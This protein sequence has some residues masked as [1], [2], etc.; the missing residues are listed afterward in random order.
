ML[1]AQVGLR[2][3]NTWRS[4]SEFTK[5]ATFKKSF[6]ET[7]KS[8]GFSG[9]LENRAQAFLAFRLML[10]MLSIEPGFNLLLI[11]DTD[12]KQHWV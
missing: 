8:R 12:V 7:L 3:V 10:C 11:F 5:L 9:L 6:L 1:R 4:G 2:V